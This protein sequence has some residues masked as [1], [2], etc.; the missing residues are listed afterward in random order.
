VE[1]SGAIAEAVKVEKESTATMSRLA[2][3]LVSIFI[4]YPPDLLLFWEDGGTFI[5]AKKH[6]LFARAFDNVVF[7]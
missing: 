4:S 2:S 1:L 6:E 3:A 5:I 7:D